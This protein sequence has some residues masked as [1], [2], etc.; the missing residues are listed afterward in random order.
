MSLL[1][2]FL[3]VVNHGPHQFS[4]RNSLASGLLQPKSASLQ[5]FFRMVARDCYLFSSKLKFILNLSR[6]DCFGTEPAGKLDY[7]IR[8][9]RW[10]Y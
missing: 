5:T 10:S 7:V 6:L 8:A 2:L 9:F 4:T 1:H 3:P